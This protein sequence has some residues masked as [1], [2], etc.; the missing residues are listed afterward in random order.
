MARSST[1]AAAAAARH[2]MTAV[3]TTKNNVRRADWDNMNAGHQ[4]GPEVRHLTDVCHILNTLLQ[5][6]STAFDTLHQGSQDSIR[7]LTMSVSIHTER[8][9]Q[10]RDDINLALQ[11]KFQDINDARNTLTKQ[12]NNYLDQLSQVLKTRQQNKEQEIIVQAAGHDPDKIQRKLHCRNCQTLQIQ[13]TGARP[14]NYDF[15]HNMGIKE[16]YA[17]CHCGT[18]T[19]LETSNWTYSDDPGEMSK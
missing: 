15:A 4:S 13:L 5:S 14:S 17:T 10:L 9:R 11:P 2:S 6:L 12:K 16:N 3:F 7:T 19:S 1:E 18:T 8:E